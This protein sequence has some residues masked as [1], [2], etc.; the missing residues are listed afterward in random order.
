MSNY[1]KYTW[2]LDN[3]H[4][5]II[6]G[7][8]QTQG[9]RS[10]VWS[11]KR[12]LFEGEFNRSIVK[13]LS[14]MLEYA[15]IP[16]QNIVPELEDI[17]LVERVTRANSL[18]KTDKNCIY[19][20]IHANA[21]QGTG[22]EVFSSIGQTK[23]DAIA[24]HIM[25]AYAKEFPELKM[26]VDKSDKDLDKESNF[27]VIAKTKMP[28]VLVECA[29]MDTLSPDC[30]LLMSE[31]GRDRIAEAIYDGIISYINSWFKQFTD[32]MHA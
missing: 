5:G 7:I 9:K 16:H 20:S 10:P 25:I 12:Q 4:G 1:K 3:G 15:S 29:F 11:D 13:R 19:I 30:E 22:F 23:S 26:R 32:I 28:A 31:D 27:Y 17:S 21:G 6:N 18:Y 8:Y 2:L 24:E 14:L